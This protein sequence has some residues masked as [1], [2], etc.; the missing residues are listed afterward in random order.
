M[1]H[2]EEK[3]KVIII[4]AVSENHVIGFNNKLPWNIP[5]DLARFKE[6][7]SGHTVIM[8]RK[9]YESMGKPLPDRHNIVLSNSLKSNEVKVASDM[10]A[11]F[12]GVPKGE[13]EVFI[14]GG[15]RVYEEAIKFAD[16]MYLTIVA[17]EY[18]G[19]TYFPNFDEDDWGITESII[20]PDFR[21]ITLERIP[22]DESYSVK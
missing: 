19:D 1:K 22:N 13:E 12:W 9:T 21:F 10:E 16:S 7:T 17:G 8:G 2:I 11:A 6:L 3:F 14:I 20:Y 5:E 15:Q 4:A 18:V